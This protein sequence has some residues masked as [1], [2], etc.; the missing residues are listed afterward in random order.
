MNE[1]CSNDDG[2]P[3]CRAVSSGNLAE[4]AAL[5]EAGADVGYERDGGYTALID[6]MYGRLIPD[7]PDLVPLVQ[8][9]V[10]RGAALDNVTVY[11]ESALSVASNRGRFDAVGVLLQ[12]GAN[13]A[14]LAWTPLMHAVALGSLADVQ[15]HLDGKPDLSARDF[16]NRTPWLLSLQVGDVAK[17]KLLLSAGTDRSDRGR[18]GQTPLA[19]PIINHHY[20]MLQWLLSEGFDPN[21]VDDFGSTALSEA[22]EAGDTQSVRLLVASG[23]DIHAKTYDTPVIGHSANLD[24]VRLLVNSRADLNDINNEMRAILTRLP[25]DGKL[26]VSREDYLAAKTRRF[27]KSNPERMNVAF[28][29]AMVTSGASAYAA[30]SH[31]NDEN[32]GAPIWCFIRFGKSI[33]ELPDGRI[34][35]TRANT[36]TLTI[37]ISAYTTTS[38]FIMGTEPS[39]FTDT[40]KSPFRQLIFTRP[41]GSNTRSTSLE[42]SATAEIE[43]IRKRPSTAWTRGHSAS[44]RSRRPVTNRAGS[45][46]TKHRASPKVKSKSG[47]ARFSG[48]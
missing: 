40:R 28:W 22:A 36:K 12:A 48:S 5:L 30:R 7:N 31:F 16:W 21:A 1:E 9:L 23:A 34:I 20:G 33:N 24:I 15:A 4:V 17:A 27:G 6:V 42:V 8:L 3:L 19:Y 29:N 38:P 25:A 43:S 44:K 2:E 41:H 37:L 18:C 14:P 45:A 47:A 11:S 13:P 46:A 32:A 10:A 35:K 26:L 39:T